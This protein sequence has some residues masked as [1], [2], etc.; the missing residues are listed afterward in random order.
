M[1]LVFNVRLGFISRSTFTKKYTHLQ[2]QNST[3]YQPN[4]FETLWLDFFGKSTQPAVTLGIVLFILH[5]IAYFGRFLPYMVMEQI[6]FFAKYKIQ[7]RYFLFCRIAVHCTRMM[8]SKI[9]SSN[10]TRRSY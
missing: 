7:V 5:E 9:M 4:A 8:R 2:Q 6:P 10:D 1:T 3:D